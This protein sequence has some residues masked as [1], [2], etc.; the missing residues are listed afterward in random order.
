M[1]PVIPKPPISRRRKRAALAVAAVVDLIQIGVFPAFAEGALS[2]LQDVLD[3]VTAI[4]L[5]AVCGFKWQFVAAF[6]LELLPV[7]DLFPTWTAMVLT[8]PSAAPAVPGE[9]QV[10]ASVAPPQEPSGGAGG[11][12]TVDVPGVL[13]PP[14]QPRSLAGR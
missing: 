7:A 2:P 10:S 8:L 11:K 13:V 5:V 9:I 1:L 14:V 4:V 12:G 3:V 6:G